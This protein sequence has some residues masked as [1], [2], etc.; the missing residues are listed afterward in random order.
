MHRGINSATHPLNHSVARLPNHSA[1]ELVRK[2]TIELSGHPVSTYSTIQVLS[3]YDIK[4]SSYR[5]IHHALAGRHRGSTTSRRTRSEYNKRRAGI[6]RANATKGE[7]A[8]IERVQ[9]A[10][11]QRASEYN[12][13]RVGIQRA[14]ATKGEQA[15]NERVHWKREAGRHSAS[16]LEARVGR[17]RAINMRK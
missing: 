15:N 2:P 5:A 13:R 17:H 7:Q 3:H 12:K 14:N 11:I 9:R 16:T 10:G 4:A 6:Q 1:T 8:Y